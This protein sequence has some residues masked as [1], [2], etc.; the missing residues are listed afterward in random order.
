MI[1]IGMKRFRN[2]AAIAG[3]AVVAACA[4]PTP[5]EPAKSEN[6]E[7]YTTQRIESNRF[8]IWFRG[9]SIPSR[10]TVDTYML[11]RAAEVTL[12]NGSDYFVIVNKDVD[13]NTGY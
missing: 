9:N 8:R 3:L 12:E 1:G 7:G 5:Y 10:Q 4:T 13:K 6:G 11:Y 2:F